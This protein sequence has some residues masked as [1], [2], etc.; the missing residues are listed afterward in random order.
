[1]TNLT[2]RIDFDS[3]ASIGPGKIRL[4]EA[5]RDT[6]SIRRAAEQCGMS[7]RQAWLLLQA[8]GEMFEEPV[9]RTLRG[10]SRGG[11][12]ALTELGEAV[13]NAYRRVEAGAASA[14][15]SDMAALAAKLRKR[16]LRRPLNTSGLARK[17]LKRKE[18]K[19]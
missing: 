1:M 11:G 6:G 10:G 5:V 9:L 7:F 3:G 13:V 15:A 2:I 14:A 12:T 18:K 16:P 17:P 19:R 4:L 8:M